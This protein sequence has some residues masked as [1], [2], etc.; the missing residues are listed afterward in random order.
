VL[1]LVPEQ[2][3]M[4]HNTLASKFWTHILTPAKALVCDIPRF[5]ERLENC[6]VHAARRH[7]GTS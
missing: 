3:C 5:Q 6:G 1:Q 7:G 2:G 4:C